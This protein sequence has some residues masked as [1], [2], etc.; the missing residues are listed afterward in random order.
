MK[1]TEE[2]FKIRIRH[3]QLNDNNS[4]KVTLSVDEAPKNAMN[5]V[6]EPA[7]VDYLIEMDASL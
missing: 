2:D 5:I 6:I 4:G 7:E 3:S 1:V